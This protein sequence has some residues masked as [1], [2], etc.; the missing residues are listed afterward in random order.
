MEM[1]QRITMC[2]EIESV[3]HTEHII[4]CPR[5]NNKHKQG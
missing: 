3:I 1:G 2:L 4:S 5:L